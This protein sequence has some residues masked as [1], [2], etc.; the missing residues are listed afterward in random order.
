MMTLRWKK[1]LVIDYR[2]TFETPE[3]KRVLADLRK[4]CP[5]L[6][7]P[8]ATASGVEVH[9][10]LVQEGQNNILKH[11]YRMLSRDPNAEAQEFAENKG[12]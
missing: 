11:I 3:G 5:L 4:R 2:R 7:A 1:Q 10:L 8:L 6:T 9:S 12:E